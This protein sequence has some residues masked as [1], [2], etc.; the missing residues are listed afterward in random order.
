[1][2]EEE[3]NKENYLNVKVYFRHDGFRKEQKEIINDIYNT[4]ASKKN[5]LLHA[6]TGIGKTDAA[7]SAA[8]SYAIDKDIKILFLTPKIS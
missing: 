6:P 7:L 1:M 2:K 3:N 5:I 8:I 4:I